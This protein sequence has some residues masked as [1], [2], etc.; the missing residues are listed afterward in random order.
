MNINQGKNVLL[1]CTILISYSIELKSQLVP[2]PQNAVVNG[3]IATADELYLEQGTFLIRNSTDYRYLCINAVPPVAGAVVFLWSYINDPGRQE[4]RLVKASG[5]FYRIKSSSGWCLSQKRVLVPT[6]EPESNDDSQLWQV[7][8][9][10]DGYYTIKSKTNKYLVQADNQAREGRLIGFTGTST[11][12]NRLKWHLIKWTNDKRKT[13]RFDPVVHGFRFINTF[14]GEDFIRW[15]G[16]CGGMVYGAL[17]YY[18]RNIPV[19]QQYYTPANQTTLQSYLYKRQNHSMFDVNTSWTD[20]EVSYN[21]RG[22]ELY[23]WGIEGTGSGRLK[24]IKDAVDVGQP[25]P[26]G[27]FAGGVRGLNN[28]DGGRHVVL[29]TGYTWGRYT[30]DTRGQVGD[31]KLLIYNPN[32]GNTFRTIVPDILNKCFFEVETGYA[33]RTYFVNNRYDGSHTPPGSIPNYP[34][35]EAEGRVRH[36]Y[37]TFVTGGDDLRGGNDNVSLIIH[38]ADGSN[39]RF[40]NLNNSARWVDKSTQ[41]VH[42]ELN[43]SVRKTDISR[44]ELITSFGSDL[45][46]DD[47]NLQSFFVTSGHGGTTYAW[48]APVKPQVY[49]HRF[50]GDQRTTRF[51]VNRY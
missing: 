10:G 14:I 39:Q 25:K 17:D 42:I 44:F 5:G 36:L 33:W 19:P 4:W 29:V 28:S 20:L 27:L 26:L 22:S 35:G 24:E 21:T 1:F 38:F 45:S 31:I 32:S 48:V 50:S 40:E 7:I 47:W 23:R 34:E 9:T 37:A 8:E 2:K 3:N 41:T 15:G 30:G 11:G 46:S 18:R 43:R 6:V 13:T 12:D 49:V 16:M 51:V